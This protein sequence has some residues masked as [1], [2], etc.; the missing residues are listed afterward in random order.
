MMKWLDLLSIKRIPD[1]SE[2]LGDDTRSPYER[3][4]N[5]ILYSDAFRRLSDKTQVFTAPHNATI[6]N[7][8][9]HT[10]EVA[11]IGRSLAKIV[12]YRLFKDQLISVEHNDL[13]PPKL[14]SWYKNNFEAICG[15]DNSEIDIVSTKVLFINSLMDIVGTACLAH[16]IGN[17]PFGHAGE[18]AIIDIIKLFE[19]K[20][21]KINKDLYNDLLHFDGN[22]YGL[23]LL[24]TKQSFKLTYA[25]M[26]AFVKY[27]ISYEQKNIYFLD[28][29]KTPDIYKKIG[30]FSQDQDSIN[31]IFSALKITKNQETKVYSRHPLTFLME[32]ADDIGYIIM[33]FEDAIKAGIINASD[34]ISPNDNRSAMDILYESLNE[35]QKEKLKKQ[36]PTLE[37]I[38]KDRWIAFKHDS[39]K[40]NIISQIR[41]Y[42]ISNLIYFV[43]DRFIENYDSIMKGTYTKSMLSKDENI[44]VLVNYHLLKKFSLTYIYGHRTELL[45]EASGYKIIENLLTSFLDAQL[46][47]EEIRTNKQKHILGILEKE[48]STYLSC[49]NNNNDKDIIL[50][51]VGFVAGM[52]DKYAIE[53]FHR[54]NGHIFQGIE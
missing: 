12:G 11:G 18:S 54:I 50:S 31:K 13:L 23:R 7:R 36:F 14:V 8:L 15:T 52:T 1:G 49:K 35:D 45:L 33:D 53:L 42:F 38:R 28:K 4:Y 5:R 43:V 51:I 29:E 20:I 17:P 37:N 44:K 27:P 25:S 10:L 41:A 34:P 39:N 2:I 24:L 26:G 3:D 19:N 16:D 30:C 40:Y 46:Q 9:T 22:S 47:N 6:H 21:T 32:A 48:C